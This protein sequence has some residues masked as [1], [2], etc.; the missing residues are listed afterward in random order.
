M[1][2]RGLDKGKD[3]SVDGCNGLG[4]MA[5][6]VSI[7]YCHGVTIPFLPSMKTAAFLML[8]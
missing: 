3:G 1:G 4:W 2:G 8:F 7:Y 6:G 5:G